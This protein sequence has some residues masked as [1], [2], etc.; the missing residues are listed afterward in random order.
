MS[1]AFFRRG[2]CA[3]N[4]RLIPER[5]LAGLLTA[6]VTHDGMWIQPER[7]QTKGPQPKPRSRPQPQLL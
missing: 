1:E 2:S 5:W 6:L 7:C 3:A 4:A